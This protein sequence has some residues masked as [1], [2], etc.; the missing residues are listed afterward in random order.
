M[1]SSST[2]RKNPTSEPLLSSRTANQTNSRKRWRKSS[3]LLDGQDSLT[4]EISKWRMPPTSS[5][6]KIRFWSKKHSSTTN[7]SEERGEK[8]A[9]GAGVKVVFCP[10]APIFHKAAYWR[11]VSAVVKPE[12]MW[13]FPNASNKQMLHCFQLSQMQ[14]WV[15][16]DC[17]YFLHFPVAHAT[18]TFLSTGKTTHSAHF[19]N[20][21]PQAIS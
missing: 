1:N 21:G 8:V 19:N 4:T 18:C 14:P 11:K 16:C 3:A 12:S 17:L 6:I 10:W 7:A 20:C 13:V 9:G 15:E 2:S 5:N